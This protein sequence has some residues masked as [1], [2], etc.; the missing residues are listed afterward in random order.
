MGQFSFISS[1]TNRSI[2]IGVLSNTK[3]YERL[4][5]VLI[6]HDKIAINHISNSKRNITSF[7]MKV[8]NSMIK[9]VKY[10]HLTIS[11]R[12]EPKKKFHKVLCYGPWYPSG[13]GSNS[14]E[15]WVCLRKHAMDIYGSDAKESSTVAYIIHDYL[16]SKGVM[17]N[18]TKETIDFQNIV[19]E[20]LKKSIIT[21]IDNKG[22]KWEESESFYQ[23]YGVFG[24]KDIFQLLAEMNSV[25]DLTGNP[26]LDREKGIDLFYS[27]KENI[28]Y[29]KLLVGKENSNAVWTNKKLELCPNQGF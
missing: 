24:G 7:L 22:N 26:E 28:I 2:K 4:G 3:L 5:V 1:D 19:K 11:T 16:I 9:E 21:M 17:C 10:R 8:V 18:K 29:P 25:E 27:N 23:G 20:H 15:F 12:Q 13:T 6:N 14:F